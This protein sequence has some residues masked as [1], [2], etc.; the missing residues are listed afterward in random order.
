MQEIHLSAPAKINLFLA[1]LGKRQDGFHEI[2][3]LFQKVSLRDRITISTRAGDGSIRLSCPGTDLDCGP[4]NLAHRAASLFR[5]ASGLRLSVDILLRKAIP[6]GGGLGGGSSDAACVLKGLNL[7]S[8][9]RLGQDELHGAASALGSDVPFFLLEQGAAYGRGRG[10][11]LEPVV[12]PH[13]WYL[14]V[15]P[16]F[17]IRTGP[18]YAQFPLT[19]PGHPTILGLPGAHVAVSFKND[20][21][22]VVLPRHPEIAMLKEALIKHG[23]RTSLMSGSGSTVFGA[24]STRREAKEAENAIRSRWR[25][26]GGDQDL[27]THVTE[28]IP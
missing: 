12:V 3:T 15:F 14:L 23:A 17:G 13:A 26:Q 21:E 9:N 22:K 7:L 10:T 6:V 8:G 4:D 2:L 16:G 20:L 28:S 1:V 19:T 24:F 25:R 18:V 11:E 5:E 27:V